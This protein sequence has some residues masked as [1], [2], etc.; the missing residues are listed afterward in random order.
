MKKVFH[1]IGT[2]FL[3]LL[4]LNS[5]SAQNIRFSFDMV[6]PSPTT[7]TVSIYAQV[8][9]GTENL[10]GYTIYLYYDNAE[11]TITGFDGS[12]TTGTPGL[13][14]GTG[15]QSS[16]LHQSENNVN[17]GI[18]HTGYFFYQN[19]D[20]AFAGD[21]MTTAPTLLLT[22]DFDHSVGN[23]MHAGSAWLAETDEVPPL[24][25]VNN[26][27]ESYDVITN[28]LQSQ[29]LP[30]ELAQFTAR[31]QGTDALLH[32]TTASE[33]NASHFEV[34]RS[35][36]GRNWM[37][38]GAQEAKGRG[39]GHVD[40]TFTD[41]DVYRFG[42][43]IRS[44]YY[45][46]RMVDRDGA[47]EYSAMK[48]VTFKGKGNVQLEVFPNPATDYIQVNVPQD[49][50]YH[51]EL[52]DTSG[53]QIISTSNVYTLDVGHLQAGTY[54]LRIWQTDQLIDEIHQVVI[55]R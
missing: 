22:I 41:M 16:I 53:K 37:H 38:V 13:S 55:V 12:P 10:T 47:Y 50:E 19:F 32:W 7:T 30:I 43:V 14:W 25:Y 18:S 44:F 51:L 8:T 2:L 21:D 27:F 20:N 23:S 5:I 49:Q 42:A 29:V 31:P 48:N 3:F 28:G 45:R 17:V 26:L 4:F 46:L 6:Q 34:E 9:S 35:I 54:Q 39:V 40:Y 52:Y 24:Q 1:T 33:I 36:D 15:N 11:T